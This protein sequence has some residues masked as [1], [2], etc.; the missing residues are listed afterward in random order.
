M[1]KFSRC[2]WLEK[3]QLGSVAGSFLT[4]VRVVTQSWE[5][6]SLGTGRP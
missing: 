1:V 5:S 6:T 3:K 2:Y 4:L